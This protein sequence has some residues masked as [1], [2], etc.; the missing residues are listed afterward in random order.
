MLSH[1]IAEKSTCIG[2]STDRQ[3][4]RHDLICRVLRKTTLID[5]SGICRW[6]GGGVRKKAFLLKLRILFEKFF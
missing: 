5:L 6:G 3:T 1:S 4:V 2:L